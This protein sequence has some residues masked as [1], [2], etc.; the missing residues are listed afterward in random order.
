G[1]PA[2]PALSRRFPVQPQSHP[3]GC[4]QEPRAEPGAM[5]S[6]MTKGRCGLAAAPAQPKSRSRGK[7]SMKRLGLTLA[8]MGTLGLM[9]GTAAAESGADFVQGM[10]DTMKTSVPHQDGTAY[11]EPKLV[12]AYNK[13]VAT[14]C[15]EVDTLDAWVDGPN[16]QI[17]P[18]KDNGK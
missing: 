14:K 11:L 6:T 5:T 7:D 1:R 18:V 12:A 4:L 2:E 10:L 3:P 8:M 9:P 15:E 17:T 13:F 16:R